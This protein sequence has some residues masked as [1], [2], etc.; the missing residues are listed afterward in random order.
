MNYLKKDEILKVIS[1]QESYKM[2]NFWIKKYEL[3]AVKN[4]N[5][6]YKRNGNRFY[7]DRHWTY[8]EFIEFKNSLTQSQKKL[9]LFFIGCGVG[10]TFYPIYQQFPTQISHLTAIDCAAKAIEI[11]KE[12]ELYDPNKMNIQQCDIVHQELSINPQYP[13]DYAFLLFVISSINQIHHFNIFQKIYNALPVNGILYVR[14]YA[15]YDGAQ[16]R[17]AKDSFISQQFY[18]RQDGTR[19]YFFRLEEIIQIAKQLNFKILY[20]KYIKKEQ[21]IKQKGQIFYRRWIQAALQKQ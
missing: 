1:N 14:D 13:Y 16:L 2:N 19:S 9:N 8:H 10:N 18:V 5:K 17:F 20:C 4:W 6:F 3:D 11:C 12:H 15:I 21:N 7:K